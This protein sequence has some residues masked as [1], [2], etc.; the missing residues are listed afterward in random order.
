MAR[1]YALL[2]V[3]ASCGDKQGV[4][5]PPAELPGHG[6]AMV[7]YSFSGSALTAPVTL[8]E[9][10]VSRDGGR[11]TL[12]VTAT[13]G[14]DERRWLQVG[15]DTPDA[16][17]NNTVDELYVERDGSKQRLPNPENRTLARLYDWVLVAASPD[18]TS[19]DS[20]SCDQRI[21]GASFSCTCERATRSWGGKSVR[22]EESRCPQFPWQRGPARWTAEDGGVLW[23]VEVTKWFKGG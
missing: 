10:I 21:G 14:S 6:A 15:P 8:R 23:Q 3:L 7:E 11:V 12:Q 2:L 4:T 1:C 19:H 16:R 5:L 13:R 20:A 18:A 22:V 9:E 17:W